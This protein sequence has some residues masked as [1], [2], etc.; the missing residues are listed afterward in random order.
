MAV[1]DTTQSTPVTGAFHFNPPQLLALLTNDATGVNFTASHE[2][3]NIYPGHDI[4]EIV[5]NS[6]SGTTFVI[7]PGIYRLT[8]PII[9]KNGDS[10]IGQTPCAPPTTECPA[11]ISGSIV[12][13]HLAVFDGRHYKV[14]D[15][16]QRGARGANT[17]CDKG[18]AGCI[19]PEDLFFDGVP[20]R[21]LKSSTLPAIGPREWWFDYATHTIYFHDNPSGHRVETSVINN[22]FSGPANAVRIRYLTVEGFAD[23]YPTGAIGDCQR[24]HPLTQEAHWVV[25]N[26]EIRLNHGFGVRVGYGSQILNN[27]IHDNG[28]LGIGGG[29]GTTSNPIT[30]SID[31]GIL[32]E[33]NIVK[34]NDY[35]HFDPGF[36]AGGF[37]VG[38]TSGITLRNNVFK[39]NEGSGIHFDEYS[40]NELVDGN[41]IADNSDGDGLGQEIGYG[42]STFRNNLVLR[43]GVHVTQNYYAYQIGVH[44]S[45]GVHA[46]CNVIEI[47]AGKGIN[48][49]GVDASDRGR[50]RYP[51]YQYLVTTGNLFRQNTVIW[52][53][54]ADGVVGFTQNDPAHQPHFFADNA[55]PDSN[56]YHLANIAAPNFEYDDNDSRR[57]QRKAFQR[58]QASGAD[59]HGTVDTNHSSGFPRVV[60]ASPKDQSSVGNPVTVTAEASDS[61]GIHRVDFY[62]DWVPYATATSNPY[63][64][65]WRNASPGPHSITAFAHSN[66]GISACYA[67]TVV[68]K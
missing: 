9:P 5:R 37:K 14:T 59:R 57:N 55:T 34:H 6:P 1:Q 21:H 4:P 43:N 53:L 63:R 16:T 24:A 19:Y 7:Y 27:Y 39:D 40:Q 15:Q 68:K 35:A 30:E 8:R 61:S 12:I 51:G 50:S 62:V 3:V 23:M 33:G 44:A 54:G 10:F 52:D 49:W 56:H 41:I 38:S 25:E 58:Y 11:I 18:W 20:Y 26:S 47:P 46:Y 65:V 45:T 36:G 31:S 28:E 32:I 29:I 48:G 17:I 22:G 42:T 64:F 13:G 67:V 2:T 66:A 60:I